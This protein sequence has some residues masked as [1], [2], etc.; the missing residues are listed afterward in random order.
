MEQLYGYMVRNGKAYGILT[1]MKGWCFLRRENGGRLYI[2]RM[3]GDFQPRAG[4]S[5]GAV[6]EGYYPTPGFS[7]MN[8]LYY[9]SALAEATP[10]L[11]E[12]PVNG[13][14]GQVTLP[15][16]GNSTTRAPTFQ[17]PAPGNAAY[18]P[19][20]QVPVHGGQGG[21]WGV[22]ILGDYEE[23]ECSQ[24]HEGVEYRD[25]QFEPWIQENILGPKTWVAKT[26]PDNTKVVLKLWDSWK[27]DNQ[28]QSH[29]ASIYLHLRSLWGKYIPCL[30]VKTALEYFHALIFQYVKV[31]NVLIETLMI[32]L[33]R[34]HHSI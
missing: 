19:G 5:A 32:R 30:R 8:A 1:T 18:D 28:A 22:W 3:F 13:V 26:L 27:F 25:L 2:T 24:Y 16:A 29:E 6:Q 15:L 17:Q 4:I 23:A 21:Q 20:A 7:I 14:P 10:N 34:C 11:P 12:T 33:L 9:L 31:P